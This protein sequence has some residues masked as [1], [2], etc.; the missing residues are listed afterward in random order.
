VSVSVRDIEIDSKSHA[1]TGVL[2]VPSN[3]QLTA[4]ACELSILKVKFL[5]IRDSDKVKRNNV[6]NT[7]FACRNVLSHFGTA[8]SLHLSIAIFT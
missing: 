1:V 6:R 5:Q 7:L 2:R 8:H 3:Q 4:S